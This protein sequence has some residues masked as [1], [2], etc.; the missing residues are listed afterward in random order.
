MSYEHFGQGDEL[1]GNYIRMIFKDIFYTFDLSDYRV[2]LLDGHFDWYKNLFLYYR[3]I[4]E[5]IRLHTL[6]LTIRS[7]G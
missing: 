3:H 5:P 2:P 7:D 1:Y 6:E 4:F